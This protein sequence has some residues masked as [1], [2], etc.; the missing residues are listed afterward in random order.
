MPALISLDNISQ[1][2]DEDGKR[3]SVLKDISFDIEAGEFLMLLG[4]S[5]SGKSTL[6]RILAGLIQPSVGKIVH[7]REAKT[8]FIFQDF[9]LFPWLTVYENV[10]FGLKM[11]DVAKPERHKAVTNQIERMGLIGF[12]G[13]F[14]RELS[15]G[16]KQRVGIAR[17][18]AINP[19]MIFLDE[20]F[21]ALDSFTAKKLRAQLVEIWQ[22]TKLTIVM[23]THLIDEALQLGD[24]I[25]VLNKRPAEVISVVKNSLPR[26]RNNRSPEFFK[27]VDKIDKVIEV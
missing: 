12:E 25:V 1:H 13:A 7:H 5:G 21:S 23:V 24:R 3:L 2:F 26:P 14:P 6:L 27:L 16:M 17:A 18:L 8:S 9:A 22:E 19:E 15:G 20:P 10:E 11:N 4:P